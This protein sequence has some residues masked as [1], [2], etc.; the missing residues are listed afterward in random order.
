MRAPTANVKANRLPKAT[1][2]RRAGGGDLLL[3]KEIQGR[4]EQARDNKGRYPCEQ[5]KGFAGKSTAHTQKSGDYDN[6]QN[7]AV[8]QIHVK[9]ALA[10][11]LGL[12]KGNAGPGKGR[13]GTL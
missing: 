13:H 8:C 1:A 12:K 11:G 3:E 4:A 5:R 2:A 6:K 7:D 9:R 10:G